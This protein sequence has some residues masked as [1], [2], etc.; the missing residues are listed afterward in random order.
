M[1]T[2]GQVR[3][4]NIPV[5][6]RGRHSFITWGYFQNKSG[7]LA[8]SP[9]SK[10]GS[11]FS[12]AD[13]AKWLPFW[14]A[15][16]EIDNTDLGLGISLGEE[17]L[18]LAKLK[19]Q[20]SRWLWCLD[21]D[22][23]VADGEFDDG[24]HSILD[25]LDTYA[26][27]SPSRTGLK[28][29][30]TTS[31]KPTTRFKIKFS[32][33]NFVERFPSI[34]KY[35]NREIEVFSKGLFLTLTGES[36]RFLRVRYIR[37]AKVDDL[38][39]KLNTW[40]KQ[41]GGTGRDRGQGVVPIETGNASTSTTTYGK[42]LPESLVQVLSY[43]DNADEQLWSDVANALARVYGDEGR[44]HYQKW[45]SGEYTKIP[46]AEYDPQECNSR[47]DRALGEYKTRPYGYGVK[48]LVGLAS[49]HPQWE[50]PALSFDDDSP[51]QD[52][53]NIIDV[54]NRYT[55]LTTE[56]LS[57]LPQ[58]K[59]RVKGLLP[60]RGLAS[61]Y[62]PSMSGKSFLVIE[63]M[64][65]V[66]NGESF[67][68]RKTVRSPVVYVALEGA[69][70][71]AK[72]IKAYETHHKKMLPNTFSVVTDSFS[73]FNSDA[74][75]FAAA[76]MEAGLGGG[77][78]VIDTL[79]QSAPAADEN[80]S[81]DMGRIISNAQLLQ[82]AI[83]GLV[84]LVH[85][86]GKDTSKGARGHSSLL[87]ALD[88]AIEVKRSAAG[89]E[90]NLAKAKDGEDGGTTPF[91]LEVV[92]LGFDEDGEPITSCIVLGD[93]FRESQPQAPRGNNQKAVLVVIKARYKKGD[94]VVEQKLLS[95]AEGVL[96]DNS[97][98]KIRA[99]EAVAGLT[100]RGHLIATGGTY[101]V[102]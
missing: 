33:S 73:L 58:T 60:D 84:V 22:G 78:I 43:I 48:H 90:W 32:P 37:E 70:G 65:K 9:M 14:K 21:F 94:K 17:G 50:E 82:K 64:A 24:V 85:H 79:A 53:T 26:E 7:T 98:P 59:W 69:G 45:S 100:E 56:Q 101:S 23:F 31:K 38:F 44:Q 19:S 39:G 54:T 2:V 76:I 72:R 29:F 49:A 46:F 52:T 40:A 68:G 93:L 91:K 47:Y 12:Y 1:T 16:L 92:H 102:V 99:K 35:A 80:T 83:N 8:K 87:G 62:G 75:A 27:L 63:L 20:P 89:R 3:A 81:S 77:V 67:F 97:N 86:T 25:E 28:V 57:Q 71:I 42:L 51:F 6:F 61:V 88:A 55:F 15:E 11:L 95:I 34:S 36:Y 13:A 4:T 96:A 10:T 18:D 41:T 66:V 5:E 74:K 30:F